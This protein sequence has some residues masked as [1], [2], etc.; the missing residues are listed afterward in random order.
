[1]L[2]PTCLFALF[3]PVHLALAFITESPVPPTVIGAAAAEAADIWMPYGVAVGLA[4]RRG[5]VAD[6]PELLTIAISTSTGSG[7]SRE[8]L[9]AIGFDADGT[10][11]SHLT[12]FFDRLMHLLSLTP[13]WRTGEP[14]WP[15]VLREQVV[16]RAL[17]RVIA[18]EI[19]HFVLRTSDHTSSGLMR[20]MHGSDELI[21]PDRSRF[22]LWRPER[23]TVPR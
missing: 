14:H 1:M 23:R 5:A 8:T 18:H 2:L 22:A 11:R 3:A 15:R 4:G 20:P 6:N 19:G 9:G 7:P 17:G 10:P 13:T 16:G 21:A 12:V